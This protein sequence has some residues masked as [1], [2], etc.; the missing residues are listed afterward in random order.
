MYVVLPL[1]DCILGKLV[2]NL[3]YHPGNDEPPQGPTK[4]G[5]N[6]KREIESVEGHRV[7]EQKMRTGLSSI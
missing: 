4:E 7:R 2:G 3:P 6:R 1:A 5:K